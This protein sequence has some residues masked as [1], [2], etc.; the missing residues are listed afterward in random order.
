VTRRDIDLL[1]IL[2]WCVRGLTLIQ[3]ARGFWSDSPSGL[4]EARRRLRTLE[5]EGLVRRVWVLARPPL[6]LD[7]G[8]L[9]AWFPGD[10]VP[11]F[12]RA[13]YRALRRNRGVVKRLPC[14]VATEKAARLMGGSGK[15]FP[16][17]LQASHDLNLGQA[18]VLWYRKNAPQIASRIV[19]EALLPKARGERV[20]D[21]AFCDESGRV[22]LL[23]EV[24]GEYSPA[25]F[26][27]LHRLAVRDRIP[28]VVW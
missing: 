18:V 11:D 28:Y 20:P 4:R 10:P 3:V 6:E 27:S 9:I 25:E 12:E 22:R 26:E 13:S 14:V 15:G 1:K 8:P 17:P 19:G 16:R 24:A 2:T 5:D 23:I 7:S 21:A